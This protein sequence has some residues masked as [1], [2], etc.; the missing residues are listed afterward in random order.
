VRMHLQDKITSINEVSEAL[1]F[2]KFVV[3]Q[4]NYDL[5]RDQMRKSW[6]QARKKVTGVLLRRAKFD[7]AARI[8]EQQPADYEL[9]P[10]AYKGK[11]P[12]MGFHRIVITVFNAWRRDFLCSTLQSHF[13]ARKQRLQHLKEQQEVC[14]AQQVKELEHAVEQQYQNDYQSEMKERLTRSA[15]TNNYLDQISS[16][17]LPSTK[18]GSNKFFDPPKYM[19]LL[20]K[21]E[22]R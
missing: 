17:E 6:A 5:V 19:E 11:Y 22:E 8:L 1:D 13:L 4:T 15:G 10:G 3:D 2:L 14:W 18:G 9:C 12:K 20:S 21:V 7:A 16:K